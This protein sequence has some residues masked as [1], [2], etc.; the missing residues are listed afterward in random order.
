MKEVNEHILQVSGKVSLMKPLEMGRAFSVS[1]DGSVYE[2]SERDNHDGTYDRVYK[3][4]PTI[5]Q[6]VYD[7]G[8]ITQTKD[9]RSRSQQLRAV[10]R[11]EWQ[12]CGEAVTQEDY[13]DREMKKIISKRVE[14]NQ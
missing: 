1:V 10:L 6:V 7:N 8:E 12:D 3:F 11:K 5:A 2:V 14:A 4:R 9:M 13:Y